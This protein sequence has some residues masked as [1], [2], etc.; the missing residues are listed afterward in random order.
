MGNVRHLLGGGTGG[1]GK[2]GEKER[3]EGKEIERGGRVPAIPFAG[4]SHM[5]ALVG[6][7]GFP[8]DGQMMPRQVEKYWGKFEW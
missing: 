2:G 5:R 1:W 3:K 6:L 7:C 8:N 4:S